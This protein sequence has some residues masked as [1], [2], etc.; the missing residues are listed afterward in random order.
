MIQFRSRL[1]IDYFRCWKTLFICCVSMYFISFNC[2]F[3]LSE[4]TNNKLS[5]FSDSYKRT[6]KKADQ[7]AANLKIVTLDTQ[8]PQAVLID[9]I[10]IMKD[11]M[12][13]FIPI[14]RI[15]SKFNRMFLT[16]AA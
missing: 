9:I 13:H 14:S 12:Q 1:I 10:N 5:E 3:N 11:S 8:L 7:V 15:S 16:P 6:E 4:V 2:I